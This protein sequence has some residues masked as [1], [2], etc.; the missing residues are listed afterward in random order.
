MGP[1]ACD[2][3]RW[4]NPVMPCG[5]T[6]PMRIGDA[7][8]NT[9]AFLCIERQIEAG[10]VASPSATV[11]FIA[12]RDGTRPHPVW[13]VT[14]RHCIEEARASGK[15][16]YIRVNAGD[17]FVDVP[18]RADDWHESDEA[19]VACL[20]WSNEEVAP[21]SVIPLGQLVDENYCYR[22]GK[23]AF[24]LGDEADEQ[25][26]YLGAEIAFLGLFSQ[27]AGKQRNLPVA[28]FGAIARLPQEAIA[29]TR[30]NGKENIE[31]YLVEARSWGGH[32]GSPVFWAHPFTAVIELPAPPSQGNRQQRRQA[33]RGPQKTVHASRQDQL[34]TLLG[35]VSAHFDIPQE[36]TT[37]GDV[38]GK[39]V[40]DVNAGM[41]VVTPAH[42]IRRLIDRE[43]V[44]EQAEEYRHEYAVEPTATVDMIEISDQWPAA[45]EKSEDEFVRFEDLAKGL[46][47]VPK[48]EIDEKRK[49]T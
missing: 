9:T 7:H 24:G 10:L 2:F 29:V 34:L 1:N 18:T 33:Q 45:E 40:T 12:D 16:T 30:P 15:P 20:Y 43:D 47:Q 31:G 22:F 25:R 36:A 37:S 19:D 32:S 42:L 6:G 27:H 5:Y 4:R 35:L 11:F 48:S 3:P 8:L 21:Q 14:A 17:S 26:V 23:Y 28:R 38:L 44:R 49:K 39:V 13:A 46:M 41:A